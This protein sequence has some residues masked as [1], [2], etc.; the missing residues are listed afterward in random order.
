MDPFLSNR[1]FQV[2]VGGALPQSDPTS[3][4]VLQ[5]G[6][7]P[8]L[9]FLVYT[10]DLPSLVSAVGV[11]CQMCA[12]DVKIYSIIIDEGEVV[13][14]QLAIN[15]VEEWSTSLCFL[16]PQKNVMFCILAMVH[17]KLLIIFKE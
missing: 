12:D 9:L 2:R 15:Q 13:N 3:S 16:L 17:S 6:A 8:P 10:F 11:E 14:L 7:L 4:D 5:G 1:S